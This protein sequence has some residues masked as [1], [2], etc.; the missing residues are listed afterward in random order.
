MNIRRAA[1]AGSVE[2]K[3]L[4]ER[5]VAEGK[6]GGWKYTMDKRGRKKRGQKI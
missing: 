5:Y 1:T 6:W 3:R 2:R 4:N